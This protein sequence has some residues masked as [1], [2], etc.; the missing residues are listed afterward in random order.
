M[1]NWNLLSALEAGFARLAGF[2]LFDLP[3]EGVLI[4][5]QGTLMAASV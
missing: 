2:N 3:K 1:I 5:V 4:C